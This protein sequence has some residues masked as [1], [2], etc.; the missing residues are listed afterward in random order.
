[1]EYWR[2]EAEAQIKAA[3][4]AGKQTTPVE[5]DVDVPEFQPPSEDMMVAQFNSA[6]R[7]NAQQPGF[8][9]NISRIPQHFRD[10]INW[11]EEVK[12]KRRLN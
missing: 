10:A 2:R 7:A 9:Q 5:R 8:D 1:L 3:K 11:A 12:A 4:Q 6:P